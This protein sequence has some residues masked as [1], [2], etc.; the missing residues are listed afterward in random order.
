MILFCL[1]ILCSEV[2]GKFCYYI[3][4][5]YGLFLF[6]I[7]T[8]LLINKYIHFLV[9]KFRLQRTC[10]FFEIMVISKKKKRV[11]GDWNKS[12]KYW[13]TISG[14]E[15]QENL[16]FCWYNIKIWRTW[17]V[18]F[19]PSSIFFQWFIGFSFVFQKVVN[20]HHYNIFFTTKLYFFIYFLNKTLFT[21]F[22]F[23]NLN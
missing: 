18:F 13:F 9:Y 2:Q 3:R 14:Q 23:W 6:T 5:S 16:I 21:Y 12:P 11:F 19:D 17:F 20:N 4:R 1:N 10:S 8:S 7:K 22:I 15:I